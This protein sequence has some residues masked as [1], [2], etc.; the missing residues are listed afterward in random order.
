MSVRLLPFTMESFA[1]VISLWKK[2]EGV[3][4]SDADSESNIR[5]YVERNP[6]MS[7]IA[8][9]D[10]DL[11]IG[12][13]LCGHDGRRG[14]IHHLAVKPAFRRRGV[15][16]RLIEACLY[17]LRAAGITKCH[18]FLLNENEKGLEFWRRIGWTPRTD[19]RIVS[20]TIETAPVSR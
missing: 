12:A 11:I 4:L 9:E 5:K 20:R 14:Y 2:S 1:D 3:A 13:V 15:G 17:S 18:I 6:G 7:F 10:R 8:A 19:V 16:R